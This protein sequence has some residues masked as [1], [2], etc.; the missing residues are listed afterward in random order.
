MGKR[1]YDIEK[2]DIINFSSKNFKTKPINTIKTRD[3][4]VLDL[5]IG[6]DAPKNFLKMYEYGKA[7]RNKI[8]KWPAYI[9]KVGHKWYPIESIT[10]HLMTRLGDSLGLNM[11]D[12]KLAIL[13][14]QVRFLSR[15]F[16]KENETLVHGAQIFAGYLE[17]LVFV[18]EVEKQKQASAMFTFQFVKEAIESRFPRSAQEIL[19]GYACMLAFDAIVGNNDRHFYN[20]GVIVNERGVNKGR[21]PPR[22]APIYD[23]ARGLF[24][25]YTEE[26][27]SSLVCHPQRNAR[28]QKYVNRSKPKTGWDYQ[29][30]LNHFKLLELIFDTYP[31][32]H[33]AL[34]QLLTPTKLESLERVVNVE[35]KELLSENRRFLLVECLK[36]RFARC[37]DAIA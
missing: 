32:L 8:H 18:E 33:P 36:M 14:G 23:S 31:S 13:K 7:K 21:K 17:D 28:I 11:A 2:V 3:Y 27:V 29:E 4:V 10:E 1:V 22:F 15:Y 25:N 19:E 16:L 12:S 30:S 26:Q 5:S 35:F 24:W 9:A 20:W 37:C 6:G 34:C